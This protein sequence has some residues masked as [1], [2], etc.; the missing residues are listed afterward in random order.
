MNKYNKATVVEKHRKE[1][2]GKVFET[3]NF[4]P[5]KILAY[6]G[7][8]HVTVEFINTGTVMT[9]VQMEGVKRGTIR[10]NNLPILYGHCYLG[11]GEYKS[12][13]DGKP[14]IEYDVWKQMVERCFN[15]KLKQKYPTYKDCFLNPNWY[16]F[17]NFAKWYWSQKGANV[18]GWHLDKDLLQ[19]G[20]KQYGPDTCCLIPKDLNR[21]LMLSKRGDKESPVG[22]H[23]RPNGAYV[24]GR[25]GDCGYVGYF[26]SADEA[27]SAYKLAKENHLKVLAEK[28]KDVVEVR[29]YEALYNFKIE[30]T[31]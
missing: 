28:Y 11:T 16:N 18:D 21:A 8:Y 24:V 29:V 22:T 9:D 19:K 31:D 3:A 5:L 2:V 17:Q 10:D 20:N 4:G 1:N 14:A 27:F 13:R 30:I 15:E 23:Q 6:E 25:V 12:V 26:Y 7:A